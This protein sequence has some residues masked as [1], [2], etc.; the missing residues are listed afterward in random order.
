M[1][2]VYILGTGSVWQNN[3][4]RYSL[5]SVEK[6]VLDLGKVFI[7]GEY[8]EWLQKAIHIPCPDT[9][10]TKWKN[11]YVKVSKA[12]ECPEISREFLLMNDDFFILHPIIA[13]NYPFYFF[14]TIGPKKS[15]KRAVFQTTPRITSD[16]LRR[17]AESF[18]NFSVHRPVRI[19]KKL[20]LDMPKPDMRMVGFS[21]RSFYCNFYRVNG[22]N[23]KEGNLTPLS[24]EKDFERLSKGRTDVSVFSHTA[25]SGVFQQWINDKFPFPSSFEK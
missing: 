20:Y 19:D 10:I 8:P 23:C 7:V 4:L 13:K 15:L 1:D 14:T 17:P 18:L 25:K 12:C 16:F 21:P 24:S 3:E 5:R 2:L 22:L 9:Y 6:N 11:A